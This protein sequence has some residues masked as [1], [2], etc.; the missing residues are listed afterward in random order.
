MT[1]YTEDVTHLFSSEIVLLIDILPRYGLPAGPALAQLADPPT[2][3][4]NIV[5]AHS[6]GCSRALDI[7]V[8]S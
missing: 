7:E 3:R 8:L 4:P 5:H 1:G 2:C 6:A